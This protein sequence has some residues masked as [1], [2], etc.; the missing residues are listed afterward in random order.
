MKVLDSYNK[1]NEIVLIMDGEDITKT[2]F[3][4]LITNENGDSIEVCDLNECVT[5]AMSFVN[6]TGDFEGLE[7]N[8]NAYLIV[9][10]KKYGDVGD[11][12]QTF[13][14]NESH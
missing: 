2:F 10:G 4:D 12:C 1:E 14:K 13:D 11:G 9:N 5:K 3:S 7:H 8:K 6:R